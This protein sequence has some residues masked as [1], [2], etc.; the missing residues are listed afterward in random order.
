MGT[1]EKLVSGEFLNHFFHPQAK[2][3]RADEKG[4][5]WVMLSEKTEL[6]LNNNQMKLALWAKG[7]A[8][9]KS[10]RSSVKIQMR[11]ISHV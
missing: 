4:E 11:R 5:Q 1:N 2:L 9:S 7:S 8:I 10:F 6:W 3:R